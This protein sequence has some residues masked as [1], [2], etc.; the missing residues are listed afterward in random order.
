MTQSDHNEEERLTAAATDTVFTR[1]DI[2][3]LWRC[4]TKDIRQLW[5]SFTKDIRQLWRCFTKKDIRQLWRCFRKDIRQLWRC[6][7]KDIRQLWRKVTETKRHVLQLW[8]KVTKTKREIRQLWGK[9]TETKMEIRHLWGK[10]T[11]RKGNIQNL[12]NKLEKKERKKKKNPKRKV[13]L[14]WC[15]VGEK[16]RSQRF[17]SSCH[18][19]KWQ[20]WRG[21]FD[22]SHDVGR[23]RQKVRQSTATTQSDKKTESY[24][25]RTAA[26]RSCPFA[27][28]ALHWHANFGTCLESSCRFLFSPQ[29]V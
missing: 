16:I 8:G 21:V 20:R 19:A 24:S 1:K 26:Q 23:V 11:K 9:A 3:Q 25:K 28:P 4:F 2:R 17:D 13:W 7:T 27:K 15:N 6:F 18:D 22:D 5:R 14:R 10:L 29:F 12:L